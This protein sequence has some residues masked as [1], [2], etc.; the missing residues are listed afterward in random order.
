MTAA[1]RAPPGF[2]MVK[3]ASGTPLPGRSHRCLT[4]PVNKPSSYRI[5][6]DVKCLDRERVHELLSRHA[7]WALGRDRRVTEAAIA[8]VP[9]TVHATVAE[10]DGDAGE[11]GEELIGFGRV[12]TDGATMAWLCDVIIDPRCRGR[13]IGKALVDRIC[14]DLE[15]LGLR[16]VILVTED[17]HEL[18]RQ[19]GFRL[20]EDGWKW[21]VR[22]A[23]GAL[24]EVVG[25]DTGSATIPAQRCRART[26]DASLNGSSHR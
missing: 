3:L 13:G 22:Q 5:S 4:G 11:T 23:P 9:W 6:D 20:V 16:R 1:G 21:M 25:P 18:Y 26:L 17:A 2:T 10:A 24:A 8:G 15:P 12:V 14:R 7:Y 19:F